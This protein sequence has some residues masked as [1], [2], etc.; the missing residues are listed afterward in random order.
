MLGYTEMFLGIPNEVTW[1]MEDPRAVQQK[2]QGVQMRW[3]FAMKFGGQREG[4][5]KGE[6]CES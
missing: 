2:H 1:K 5:R 6:K 3:K 4:K